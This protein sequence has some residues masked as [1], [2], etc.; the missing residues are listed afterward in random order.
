M[1]TETQN[2]STAPVMELVGYG[3]VVIE[4]GVIIDAIIGQARK[5]EN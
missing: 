2:E 1:T 3:G 4:P 5:V